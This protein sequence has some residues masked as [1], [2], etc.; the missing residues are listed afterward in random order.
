MK[1]NLII[2]I[3]FETKSVHQIEIIVKKIL[4]HVESFVK[5]DDCIS[6]PKLPTN[7]FTEYNDTNLP[8]VTDL[9]NVDQTTNEFSINKAG[10]TNIPSNFTKIY[11]MN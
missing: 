11:D 9:K 2:K 7:K 5:H 1:D 4:N 10:S 8:N 6:C 3:Q